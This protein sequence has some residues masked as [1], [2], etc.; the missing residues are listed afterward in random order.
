MSQELVVSSNPLETS[1]AILEN[2]RLVEI[3]V[4]YRTQKAIAGGIYKGR[5]S[6]VLPGMQ[7][8]FLKIGLE[9]EAFLYVSDMLDLAEDPDDSVDAETE[10][11][12]EPVAEEP[13]EQQYRKREGSSSRRSRR[14]GRRR[15]RRPESGTKQTEVSEDVPQKA[16][17]AWSEDESSDSKKESSSSQQQ[18]RSRARKPVIRVLPGESLAKYRQIDILQDVVS[19]EEETESMGDSN[20]N[21]NSSEPVSEPEWL[22]LDGDSN[23]NAADS[24]QRM[25]AVSPTEEDPN[26]RPSRGS[27]R[28]RR[29]RRR[30]RGSG[31]GDSPRRGH[32]EDE[33]SK[34]LQKVSKESGSAVDPQKI[35]ETP[36]QAEVAAPSLWAGFTK[37]ILGWR[38]KPTEEQGVSEDSGENAIHNEDE[39]PMPGEPVQVET[40]AQKSPR[41]PGKVVRRTRSRSDNSG[42]NQQDGNV[43]NIAD[44]L[45]AGQE[46]IVQV[47]KEPIDSKGARITAHIN[48]PGRYM[49]YMTSAKRNGVS[50]KIKPESERIRLRKIIDENSVNK[51]GGFVIRTTG[52]K[53]SEKELKADMEFL[54]KLWKDIQIKA[55]K[56]QAP[57]K[58]HSEL[59]IVERV[60]RDYLGRDY[61][62]IWV[63]SEEEYERI[64]K[65]IERFQPQLLD[66]V[67]LYNRPEA[68]YDAFDITKDI[69]KALQ[70]KVWLK[71][72]GYLVINQT[73]ALVAIDVNTGRYVGKSDRLEDT[74]LKTNLEAAKEIVKQLRLRDLGGII[75]IDF[76]D[77]EDK[78][79]RNELQQTLMEALRQDRAPSRA[80]PINDF[81]IVVI[82]RKRARQSLEQAMCI[83]C[84]VCTGAGT[85]K[86]VPTVLS[87]VFKTAQAIAAEEQHEE[88]EDVADM[89]L[90]I[91][92][93]VA[94]NLKSNSNSDL[95][96]L[97]KTL[98]ASIIVRG[99]S[100]LHLEH[101]EFN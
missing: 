12:E 48:L 38:K 42:H 93:D 70:S 41:S 87:E 25:N 2:D 61:K 16:A 54:F 18:S 4:E 57:A 77:M 14:G 27:S 72:G 53:I 98:G 76:I 68:I 52:R 34:E 97:E 80:L 44:I 20:Q 65:F 51:S 81:G 66:R 8:A 19:P 40:P 82:T 33:S 85:I 3:Y 36:L 39:R 1:L 63:D 10:G 86:S 59:D 100:S 79:S 21:A 89:T 84:P 35:D 50:R 71:S 28:R 7:S 69:E 46:V 6:R 11:A 29:G 47:V 75:V 5:V 26:E 9:R 78:K 17:N 99:D 37:G 56:C 88:D 96:N 22:N 91:H 94:K 43:P 23:G 55:E 45:E 31:A 32:S 49:M 95:E 13:G 30:T 60:L 64:V 73:E 92:P 67:K 58:L 74:V 15:Q 101:F 24:P 90:R 62:A 83:P